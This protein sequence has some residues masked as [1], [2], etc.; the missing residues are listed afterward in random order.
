MNVTSFKG[1]DRRL[2]I[3]RLIE[4]RKLDVCLLQETRLAYNPNLN[5]C[6]YKSMVCREGVGT[7]IIF[8]N[9]LKC[10]NIVVCGLEE[11]NCTAM[12]VRGKRDSDYFI[13]SIYIPC[14]TNGQTV[15]ADLDKIMNAVSG[16]PAVIGGDLN[17]HSQGREAAITRWIGDNNC[18]VK[19]IEP[20]SGT[21]RSGNKLDYFIFTNEFT[22]NSTCEVDD[23]GLEHN[24]IYTN[25]TLNF[26]A[27]LNSGPVGRKWWAT[28]WDQFTETAA[29]NFSSYIPSD[30]C[31]D[32]NE[33]DE[34]ICRL[35]S[36]IRDVIEECVPEGRMGRRVFYD[37]PVEINHYFKE[38][39]RL[40]VALKRAKNKWRRDEERIGQLLISITEADCRINE[41]IT[42]TENR[43]IEKRMETIN[44]TPHMDK[45]REINKLMNRHNGGRNLR[46]KGQD[47]REFREGKEVMKEL[48]DF[49]KELYRG[50]IPDCNA[51][52]DVIEKNSCLL[53]VDRIT[54]FSEA[55]RATNPNQ[56][57]EKFFSI[58]SML[59]SIK[60]LKN[61]ISA[62]P[63]GIPNIII[64]RLPLNYV[65][66]L[67]SICNNCINNCYFPT[68]WKEADIIPIP[69]RNGIIEAKDIR[70]ISLTPNLGK[71]LES[72]VLINLKGELREEAI[73]VYQF[74]FKEKHS[75]VDALLA[76][77][78]RLVAARKLSKFTAIASL[79]IKKAFDSVWHEG[80]VYKVMNGGVNEQTGKMIKSFLENRWACVKG[81]EEKSDRFRISRGVP[82]GSKMGPILYNVYIGDLQ[83]NQGKGGY[84][85]QYADDTLVEHTS[86]NAYNATRHV[87]KYCEQLNEFLNN[88]GIELNK[89]KTEF[90]LCRP[91]R[92]NIRKKCAGGNPVL[93]IDKETI[94]GKRELKYLGVTFSHKGSFKRHV[95]NV[96]K[97]G[98][99]A[100]GAACRLLRNG[101]LKVAVKKL[102]YKTLI[103]PTMT[104]AVGIWG[105]EVLAPILKTER[106]VFR[107]ILNTFMNED[108]NKFISNKIIYELIEM[109]NFEE[110]TKDL[111]ERCELRWRSHLNQIVKDAMES[112]G[113][114][115]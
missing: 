15:R 99:C 74:G 58:N 95:S 42:S 55:N 93:K 67:T 5:S 57:S 22:V 90:M 102:I 53:N 78:S 82:Q 29:V 24:L 115:V 70:P 23:V 59:L 83:L 17:M 7:M 32:N 77:N 27:I 103:R 21:F 101:T 51:L 106:W 28:N 10:N 2:E 43:A 36:N 87:S 49:Y 104:Y 97:R 88:W 18:S 6:K 65:I 19:L 30:V 98:R 52:D 33:I 16:S 47:G 61:K 72:Q 46:L 38:R 4:N 76:L 81:S 3:I 91:V 63:D 111:I 107:Y 85:T 64:R 40:K 71:V 50:R 69:K 37:Y 34:A 112:R 100:T 66:S 94:H 84:I 89:S 109:K 41:I 68:A 80:V 20:F 75:T 92:K 56:S 8:S 39:R 1:K 25:Y 79:D 48:G 105:G 13:V 9:K 96:A 108:R 14:S 44:E 31:L 62:G 113:S 11:V 114:D 35:T 54:T 73:P 12:R 45:F 60:E 86:I 26:R 110:H